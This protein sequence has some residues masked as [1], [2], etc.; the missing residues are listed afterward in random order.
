M[1]LSRLRIASLLAGVASAVPLA[2][3]FSFE[4][5]GGVV[6]CALCLV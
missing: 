4:W 2:I 6:P 1:N 3:V 5:W